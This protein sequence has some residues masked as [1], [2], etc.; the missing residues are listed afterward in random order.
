MKQKTQQKKYESGFTLVELLAVIAIMMVV[1]GTVV[2]GFIGQRNARNLLI[3]RNETVTN[4]RKV[5]AYALSSKTLPSDVG[6]MEGAKYYILTFTQDENSYT[7]EALNTDYQLREVEEINLPHN[8]FVSRLRTSQG[9]ADAGWMQVIVGVPFGSMYIRDSEN[10]GDDCITPIGS[11]LSDPIKVARLS[12]G[13]VT[14]E[15][16]SESAGGDPRSFQISPLTGQILS[17]Q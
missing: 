16:Q 11:V 7:I 9:G 15:F 2:I 4:I 8:I 3:A 17:E 6:A 14:L 1:G 12:Q 13:A 5:Q 10:C